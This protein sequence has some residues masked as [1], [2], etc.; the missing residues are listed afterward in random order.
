[1]DAILRLF[2]E[3]FVAY[4]HLQ[5]PTY[6]NHMS[7][8]GKRPNLSDVKKYVCPEVFRFVTMHKWSENRFD[9]TLDGV[10]VKLVVWIPTSLTTLKVNL[11]LLIMVFNYFLFTLN[12]VQHRKRSTALA[13]VTVV[14]GDIPKTFPG[15]A[16]VMLSHSH[17]N[18]GYTERWGIPPDD[19]RKVVVYRTEEL[20][21]VLLHELIHLYDIDFHNY[22]P[23]FDNAL[24]N[25]FCLGVHKP[26][27]NEINPLALYESFTETLASY[28][29]IIAHTLF[30]E[31]KHVAS[32]NDVPWDVIRRGVEA[33]FRREQLF[34]RRQV[35]R[36]C[37]FASRHGRYIEDSHVFSYYIVKWAIFKHFPEF[38]AFVNRGIAIGTRV[39]EYLRLV[40]RILNLERT[41]LSTC[42]CG[43]KV[44]ESKQQPFKDTSR[45]TNINWTKL[46]VRH[47]SA[48][49]TT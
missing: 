29:N 2:V 10:R 42:F 33:R 26:H 44:P 27:K 39:D 46:F 28:G 31:V 12:R 5:Q 18:S 45:M 20:L 38:I 32:A 35:Q 7:S 9:Y 47:R 24:M 41:M 48:S 21:K 23:S 37:W 36:I 4:C 25:A 16:G 34:Y 1:M 43:G 13:D 30:T 22:D 3:A 49:K 19:Q 8:Q 40:N 14:C 6:T 11:P 15:A 17:I